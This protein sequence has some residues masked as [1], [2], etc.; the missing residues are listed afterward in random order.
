MHMLGVEG[1]QRER[2]RG[3]VKLMERYSNGTQ[4]GC[5]VDR[6]EKEKDRQRGVGR[7]EVIV[8]EKTLLSLVTCLCAFS[9][10]DLLSLSRFFLS[11]F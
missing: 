5:G 8:R 9:L 2:K 7:G 4:G 10:F 11:S 6:N 1:E 3:R